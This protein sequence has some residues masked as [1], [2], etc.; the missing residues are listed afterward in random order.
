MLMEGISFF[1]FQVCC[2]LIPGL[3]VYI[4]LSFAEKTMLGKEIKTVE[5]PFGPAVFVTVIAFF[6]STIFQGSF[7]IIRFFFLRLIL[8]YR[9]IF[10]SYCFP[11]H[12]CH[13]YLLLLPFSSFPPLPTPPSSTSSSFLLLPLL[14]LNS[15]IKARLCFNAIYLILRCL[16]AINDSLSLFF[17]NFLT[18]MVFKQKPRKCTCK[19]KDQTNSLE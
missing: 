1:F 10:I 16:W 5:T 6:F 11:Y 3:I 7:D 15:F 17:S 2:S 13:A 14:L 9:I 8:K 4:Y 19:P 18:S 12:P